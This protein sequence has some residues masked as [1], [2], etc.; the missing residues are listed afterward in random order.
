MSLISS[1]DISA[2]L[3]PFDKIFSSRDFFREDV[4]EL[5]V[6]NN[7]LRNTSREQALDIIK[8]IIS[9][10]CSKSLLP[11]AERGGLF[12]DGGLVEE[13]I[14]YS[15]EYDETEIT[16]WLLELKNRKFGFDADNEGKYDL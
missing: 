3:E 16:A 2:P 10:K 14:G 7:Y 11:M 15:A 4:Y 9:F 1:V 13:L 12:S 5:A 8:I 6:K